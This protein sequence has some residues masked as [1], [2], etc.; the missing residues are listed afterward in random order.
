MRRG[1][2]GDMRK[3]ARR[4][5]GVG[6]TPPRPVQM[7]AA[8]KAGD[9]ARSHRRQARKRHG[10][11]AGDARQHRATSYTAV[12]RASHGRK[13]EEPGTR[14]PVSAKRGS[15]ETVARGPST[16]SKTAGGRSGQAG[17]LHA[18]CG[19]RARRVRSWEADA[20]GQGRTTVGADKAGIALQ[21][22]PQERRAPPLRDDRHR[23]KTPRGSGSRRPPERSPGSEKQNEQPVSR[24]KWKPG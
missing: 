12:G 18:R 13:T 4:R 20:A 19:K 6:K 10:R 1:G 7:A 17:G 2:G 3:K 22:T 21:Q 11:N 23:G 15:G 8:T 5:R 16:T 24:E 14:K 9:A